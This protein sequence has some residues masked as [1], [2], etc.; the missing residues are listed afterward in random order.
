MQD[1]QQWHFFPNGR[2][3][4]RFTTWSVRGTNGYSETTEFWGAYTIGFKPIQPDILH[5]YA[6]NDVTVKLDMGDLVKLTL[7][8]GRRN[9]FWGKGCF[10]HASWAI[11]QKPEICQRPAQPDTSLINTGVSL[12]TAIAPITWGAAA[13]S[14]S[15]SRGRDR[16][17]DGQRDH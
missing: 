10:P 11:E 3:L 13:R 1:T 4:V 17:A 14:R 16:F 12:S 6:D 8:D 7:E 5:C 2:L 15:G 9:L